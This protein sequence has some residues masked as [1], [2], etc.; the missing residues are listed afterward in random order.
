M[1]KIGR[2]AIQLPDKTTLNLEGNLVTVKGEK[3]ELAWPLPAGITLEKADQ[4]VTLINAE[5]R[6]LLLTG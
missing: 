3:G 4:T 1:S 6:F 5:R 2:L